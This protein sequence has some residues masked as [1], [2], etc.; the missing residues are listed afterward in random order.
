M[1]LILG[2]SAP[3]GLEQSLEEATS[4]MRSIA[5]AEVVRLR[6]PENPGTAFQDWE[7]VNPFLRPSVREKDDTPTP[8][9]PRA[10]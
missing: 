2:G 8:M 5:S 4:W 6:D 10:A 9:D 3:H 7:R 1:I